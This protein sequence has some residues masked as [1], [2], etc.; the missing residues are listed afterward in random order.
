MRAPK[1]LEELGQHSDSERRRSG[2][3]LSL[4]ERA[5]TI[6]VDLGRDARDI[7]QGVPGSTQGVDLW[8]ESLADA[9]SGEAAHAAG[10]FGATRMS[11]PMLGGAL[12]ERFDVVTQMSG[13]AEFAAEYAHAIVQDVAGQPLRVLSL[14]RVAASQRAAGP[15]EDLLA[16][17]L[18][19][20]TPAITGHPAVKR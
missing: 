2:H 13:I 10:G 18:I 20:E 16:V 9:R 15:P 6:A 7:L 14:E 19:E 17:R 11:P 5:A 3:D 4:R 8:F 1:A 12:G